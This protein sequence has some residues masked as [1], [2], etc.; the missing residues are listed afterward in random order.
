V[1]VDQT[2]HFYFEN[3]LCD[4]AR[5]RQRLGAV[6]ERSRDPVTLMVQAD[7]AAN[8]EVLVRLGVIARSLG[9][10]EML[11]AVRPPMAPLAVPPQVPP[12]R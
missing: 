5:L 11:H 9:I 10:R 2:G 12:A 8:M 7:K 1:A 3:Q 4:E 6:V